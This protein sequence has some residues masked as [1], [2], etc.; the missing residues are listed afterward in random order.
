MPDPPVL[1]IGAGPAGNAASYHLS[2]DEQA[3]AAQLRS[4]TQD[5]HTSALIAYPDAEPHAMANYLLALGCSL[6]ADG[7]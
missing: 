7:A 4:L 3:L 5:Y 2:G 6:R 1:I